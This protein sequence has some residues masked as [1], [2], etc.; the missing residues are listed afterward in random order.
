MSQATAE[1][2]TPLPH[3]TEI[4]HITQR[5]Q[6]NTQ[7]CLLLTAHSTVSQQVSPE[8]K[9]D[10]LAPYHASLENRQ[11]KPVQICQAQSR[12]HDA[13]YSKLVFTSTT[14]ILTPYIHI[15]TPQYQSD[16]TQ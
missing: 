1:R 11:H 12:G 6:L 4:G 2:Q 9:C 5:S 8:P 3:Y 16:R 15:D 13:A 10:S 14:S 7:L